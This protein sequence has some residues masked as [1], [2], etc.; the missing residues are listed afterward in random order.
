MTAGCFGVFALFWGSFG[1]VVLMMLWV[2][3]DVFARLLVVWV[4][5]GGLLP[6]FILFMLRRFTLLRDLVVVLEVFVAFE[7][8]FDCCL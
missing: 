1:C 8:R 2:G 4:I 3:L 7:L 6:C 5:C